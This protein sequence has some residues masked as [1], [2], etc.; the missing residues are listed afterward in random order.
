MN[1]TELI[2]EQIAAVT[3]WRGT[4]MEKLRRFIHEADSEIEE[5]WKW[6]V[7]VYVHGG[8][9]CA[10]SA[11]KDHVKVNFFKGAALKDSHHLLNNGLTSKNHRAIDFSESDKLNED[12]F[13]ELIEE[14][15]S[16][17]TK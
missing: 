1:P 13:K 11:F 6:D 10:I 15:V 9:V 3:D 16:L 8:M 4:L 17:N 14:A 5:Q 2:D 12:A 7:R